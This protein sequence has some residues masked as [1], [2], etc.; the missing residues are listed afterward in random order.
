MPLLY[1]LADMERWGMKVDRQALLAYQK[2][3]AESLET[4]QRKSMN[5]PAKNSI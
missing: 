2:Q 3:L 1:V 4:S 5:F